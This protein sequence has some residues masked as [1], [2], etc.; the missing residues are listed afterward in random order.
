MIKTKCLPLCSEPRLVRALLM[1]G[2]RLQVVKAASV[3]HET[4][5][6]VVPCG[7][8]LCRHLSCTASNTSRTAML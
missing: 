3:Q 7:P 2:G 1:V 8:Q 4:L 6:V 5:L